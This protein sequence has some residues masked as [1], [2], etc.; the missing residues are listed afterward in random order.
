MPKTG[1]LVLENGKIFKGKMFGA[2]R[3]AFGELV[4]STAMTGYLETLTDSS[5][6]GQVILQTFPLVGNYGT[7]TEDL[8][9][10]SVKASAYIV[11]SWCEEPSNFRCE[12]N[13]DTFL[14]AGNIPGLYGIDTRQVTK[15]IRD[16]GSMNCKITQ[17]IENLDLDSIKNYKI[18]KAVESVSCKEIQEIKGGGKYKTLII[19]CGVKESVKRRL[20]ELGCDVVLAPYN[21]SAEQIK[22]IAPDGIIISSGSGNPADY[23][24]LADNIKN[25]VKLNI[26]VFAIGL[27]HQLLALAHGF[28]TRKLKY[29]HRGA[30][31]P[32]KNL[33]DGRLYVTNQNHGY[34]VS[35]E[36]IDKNTASVYFE[37]VTDKSCEGLE[38]K[39]MPVFSTE[40]YPEAANASATN[41]SFLF[42][43]FIKMIEE[44]KKNKENR[45]G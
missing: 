19:D 22:A 25:I 10:G 33:A 18:I 12:G 21:T 44:N 38:Y 40:F 5:S 43:K 26:P 36:S 11:K 28:K 37:N 15:I 27:G 6:Y 42:D 45:G 2:E 13:L 29:G 17:S 7:I 8:E 24:E 32:V 23:L 39:G 3:E 30:N 14:K 31:Q 16:S 34:T 35:T 9:S 4:F 20:L 1:Y 41:T